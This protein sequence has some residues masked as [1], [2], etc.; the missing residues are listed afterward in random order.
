MV[1]ELVIKYA[2]FLK[3]YILYLEMRFAPSVEMMTVFWLVG[4]AKL[5]SRDLC[6]VFRLSK[7]SWLI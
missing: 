3:A 4:Q 1:K 7:T 6:S 2:L 5:D